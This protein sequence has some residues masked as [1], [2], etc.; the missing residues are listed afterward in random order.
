MNKYAQLSY[1]ERCTIAALFKS[2]KSLRYI[3][4]FLGRSPSTIS[5]E[6]KRN[7]CV[8]DGGYRS[9]HAEMYAKGRRKRAHYLYHFHQEHWNRVIEL[10]EKKWSP[11]QISAYLKLRGEFEISHET[12]YKHIRKDRK[13]GGGLYKHLRIMPKVRRKRYNSRDSRGIL[14]GKKHISERPEEV[15]LRRSVGHWEGDTVVGPP[16]TR[17]CIVTLVERKSGYVIIKKSKSR[18]A[19]NVTAACIRA[20]QDHRDKVESITFD[21]GTEFHSYKKLESRFSLACYF[22]TP[23]HSWERGS[24]ENTNGLIRQ[25]IPKKKKFEEVSPQ[26]CHWIADQLNERPRRRLGFR[27]P[28]EVYHEES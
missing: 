13:D 19:K 3:A 7:I 22:A 5:R 20:I 28:K 25:Y 9:S 21:N 17:H 6:R 15:D 4:D 1:E 26:F 2:G 10:L 23:Y 18:T 14:R 16:G 27:S 11:E 8:W 24:N 12:I